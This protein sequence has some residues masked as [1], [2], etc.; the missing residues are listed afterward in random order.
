MKASEI[1]VNNSP[2]LKKE[3]LKGRRIKVA[4]AAVALKDFKKEGETPKLELAF[5]GAQKRLLLNKSNSKIVVAAYGDDTDAWIGKEL[6]VW[7]DPSVMMKGET[8][9]GIRVGVPA[10]P[11]SNDGSPF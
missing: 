5:V 10:P 11:V 8:V 4:I 9:G 6:E 3:D 1:Y 7:Y 2:Y